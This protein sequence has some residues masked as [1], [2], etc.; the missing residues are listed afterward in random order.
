MQFVGHARNFEPIAFT[1]KEGGYWY[2]WRFVKE[3]EKQ[4][5]DF[6]VHSIAFDD[7]SVFDW[8]LGGWRTDPLNTI[9]TLYSA[10]CAYQRDFVE[11]S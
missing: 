8:S 6:N 7:G 9:E 4:T 5:R 11:K 10:G 1:M 2:P 3:I